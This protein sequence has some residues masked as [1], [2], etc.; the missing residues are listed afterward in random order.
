MIIE[1]IAISN[2]D[3][4]VPFYYVKRSSMEKLKKH[5]ASGIGSF[6]KEHLLKHRSK[7]FTITEEDIEKLLKNN[8]F[9][10]SSQSKD[11]SAEDFVLKQIKKN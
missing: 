5:W 7:N 9:T 10:K 4:T 6:N 11:K 1:E 8:D 3:E 2:R